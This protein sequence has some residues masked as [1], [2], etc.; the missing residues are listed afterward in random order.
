[1]PTRPLP[2]NWKMPKG[3]RVKQISENIFYA[4]YSV[5][6]KHKN[7]WGRVTETEYWLNLASYARSREA[8]CVDIDDYVKSLEKAKNYPKYYYE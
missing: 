2:I 5:K 4:Q 3:Y 6:E 1:M 7:F 8:A